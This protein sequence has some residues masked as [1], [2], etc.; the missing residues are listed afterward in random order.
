MSL[1]RRAV[2]LCRPNFT[3]GVSEFFEKEGSRGV[4]VPT[5]RP[6]ASKELRL[7][8]FDD[9]HKLWYVLLKERNMLMTEIAHTNKSKMPELMEH[10]KYR[11]GKTK[12]SM[13]RLLTVVHERKISEMRAKEKA[14]KAQ[15]LLERQQAKKARLAAEAAAKAAKQAELAAVVGVTEASGAGSAASDEARSSDGASTDASSPAAADA[16]AQE[17]S[18]IGE[19][20]NA[21]AERA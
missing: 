14:A 18:T 2:G 1:L 19:G 9:L 3:R 5:G 13:S 8:S 16:P 4:I 21:T 12:K 11:R 17:G 20:Q 6:W 10:L 7:K 15:E